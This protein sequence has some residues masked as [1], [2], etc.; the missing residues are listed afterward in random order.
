MITASRTAWISAASPETDQSSLTREHLRA[1][2]AF[3]ATSAEED[4][5][6]AGLPTKFGGA[7]AT[8]QKTMTKPASRLSPGSYAAQPR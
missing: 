5:P 7:M 4:M 8:L 1:V 2:I 3:A 6:C